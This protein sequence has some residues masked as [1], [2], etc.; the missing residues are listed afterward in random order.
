[1]VVGEGLKTVRYTSTVLFMLWIIDKNLSLEPTR[2]FNTFR[3]TM[4]QQFFKLFTH[5][6]VNSFIM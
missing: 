5:N 3:V 4:T 6:D 2:I 1:M